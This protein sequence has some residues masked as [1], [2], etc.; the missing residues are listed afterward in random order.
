MTRTP[1]RVSAALRLEPLESRTLLSASDLL[2]R[3][4]GSAPTPAATRALQRLGAEVVRSYADGPSVVK[5]PATVDAVL[6][7]RRLERVPGVLYAEPDGSIA[8]GRAVY[9]SDS[10]L[11][12]QWGLNASNDVDIDA[13]EAWGVTP[14][15]TSVVVAVLDTG[16][17]VSHPELSGRLW[18]NPREIPGNG[19]DDDGNGFADDIHGWDF[20]LNTGAMRDNDGHGTHVSGIIAAQANNGGTIGVAPAVKVMPLRFID[21][22]GEGAISDAVDGIYYAVANG[23]RVINAS[24]GG[25][26][27]SQALADAI[28]YAGS[29]NVVF[30]TAAGNERVNND[31]VRSYPPSYRYSNTLAVAAVDASGRLASFSNYGPRTVDIAAP[32]VSVLSTVPGGY[33]MMS[34]TSMATPY[35]SGVVALVL[36]VNPSA[37]AAQ[38]VQWVIGTAKPMASLSGRVVSGGMVSAGRAVGAIPTSK[39]EAQTVNPPATPTASATQTDNEVRAKILG[40]EEYYRRTGGTASRFVSALHQAVIGRG[41]DRAT[42]LQLVSQ[43]QRGVSREQVARTLLSQLAAQQLKVAEWL[44]HDLKLSVPATMLAGRADVSSLASMLASGTPDNDVRAALFDTS[45]YRAAQGNTPEGFVAGLYRDVLG[46]GLSANELGLWVGRLSR[47]QSYYEVARAI[48]ASPEARQA[49]VAGWMMR[50]LGWSGSLEQAKA[51]A[52]VVE[53]ASWLRG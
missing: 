45:T 48:L 40:T 27:P 39:P 29:Q 31:N 1:R 44:V 21:D 47:G 17:D 8:T 14:G 23:A 19:R 5:L 46:R 37:S 52:V 22:S 53:I 35:V 51:N 4:A 24:W 11:G 12:Q 6:A 50:D 30:V 15:S 33:E 28:R 16:V 3:F 26:S 32:G 18:V 2:V 25:G 36:S 38:V 42:L 43:L 20:A 49:K 41:A 7:A 10:A 9:P 34:G 13:P